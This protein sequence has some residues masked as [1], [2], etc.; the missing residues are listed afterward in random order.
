MVSS[1]Q[2][3]VPEML[4]VNESQYELYFELGVAGMGRHL[5]LDRLVTER[6]ARAKLNVPPVRIVKDQKEQYLS[7]FDVLRRGRT[8]VYCEDR[9]DR[10]VVF[11]R[12]SFLN[13]PSCF[14]NHGV[15][16]TVYLNN[17]KEGRDPSQVILDEQPDLLVIALQEV[18]MRRYLLRSN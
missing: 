17:S 13:T 5:Y 14:L 3:F 1:I 2:E 6:L 9:R 7:E 10:K 4:L 16:H 18:L 11:V 8:D 15:A 12:D